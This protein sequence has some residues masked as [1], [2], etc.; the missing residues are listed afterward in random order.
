MA[1]LFYF[2]SLSQFSLSLD[3]MGLFKVK[4]DFFSRAEWT[5]AL[6]GFNTLIET[7]ATTT[8]KAYV[9][10]WFEGEFWKLH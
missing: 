3:F 10:S 5:Y 4:A 9:E 8:V 6:T 7:G 2:G 1:F